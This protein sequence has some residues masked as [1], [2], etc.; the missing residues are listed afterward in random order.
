MICCF[1]ILWNS[2][3]KALIHDSKFSIVSHSAMSILYGGSV[4]TVSTL[5]LG[6]RFIP[7]KQSSLYILFISICSTLFSYLT[8][9]I[10]LF[11]YVD[12]DYSNVSLLRCSNIHLILTRYIVC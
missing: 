3:N 8:F 2:M 5:P 11:V 1:D 10:S 6:M 4:I 9:R 12:R 7:S